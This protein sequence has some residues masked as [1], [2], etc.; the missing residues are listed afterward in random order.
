VS[1]S[2]IFDEKG[3]ISYAIAAFTD[4]TGRK[5]SEA[6]RVKFTEELQQAKDRLAEY[7]LTLEPVGATTKS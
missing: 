1:V 4:I 2:P 3:Q 5:R 7:S 6:E